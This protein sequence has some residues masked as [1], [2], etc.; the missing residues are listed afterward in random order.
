MPSPLSRKV[1]EIPGLSY[2]ETSTLES[3]SMILASREVQSQEGSNGRLPDL[4]LGPLGELM[5][6]MPQRSKSVEPECA[7][8]I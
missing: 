5:T 6:E 4:N 7:C 2:R 8:T 1:L 3:L